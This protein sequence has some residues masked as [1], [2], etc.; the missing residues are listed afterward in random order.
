VNL[1]K[2]KVDPKVLIIELHDHVPR[3]DENNTHYFE[4]IEIPEIEVTGH[5]F[6]AKRRKT[7]NVNGHSTGVL[8][9]QKT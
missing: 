5:D 3:T 9:L 4:M 8:F 7:P 2:V 6:F 1:Y